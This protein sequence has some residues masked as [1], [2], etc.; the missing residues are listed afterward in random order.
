MSAWRVIAER[1]RPWPAAAAR[2]LWS[3]GASGVRRLRAA[4]PRRRLPLLVAGAAAAVLVGLAPRGPLLAG[5][6]LLVAAVARGRR[7]ARAA[8]PEDP[9]TRAERHRR[10]ATV[11][12]ALV[13][14]FR[15]PEEAPEAGA[16]AYGG[17]WEQAVAEYAFDDEG[18]VAGLCLHYPAHFPDGD[19]EARSRVE[20]VLA[21]KTGG[22]RELA[23]EWD[24]ERTLLRLRVLPPL[25]V[26]LHAQRFVTGP[27]ETVLGFT[28]PGAVD[29]TM[30]V[31]PPG[32]VAESE[33]APQTADAAPV[34]WR[35]GP[36]CTAAHLLVAAS[37]GAGA[38][39]LLRSI[40]L[41]A[42]R[43]GE[44]LVVDGGGSGEFACFLGRR[45][46]L[47]VESCAQGA[48]GALEWVARETERRLSLV[49]R[50]RQAPGAGQVPRVSP[51][52]VVVDRPDQLGH[53]ARL[54]G[55]A[56]PLRLLEVPLRHGRAAQV[57]VVVAE[58][59]AGLPSL[60]GTV[61]ECAEARVVLGTAPA[62][63]VAGVLGAPPGGT[64]PPRAVPGRGYARLGP[65]PVYRLQVPA[66]PDPGDDTARDWEREAV[67][68]LLPEPILAAAPADG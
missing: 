46:V 63:E 10:L 34:V 5:A 62:W 59:L 65:G 41:Q 56:D 52:W 42:L 11:Y 21:A 49:G 6:A 45:G 4:P 31:L 32:A 24:P 20:A 38:T 50:A 68:D 13:P 23:F 35:T 64:P 9:A 19:P 37:P 67:L 60:S 44:I 47:S 22:D 28:D 39:S 30:P 16:Y 57:A 7:L 27:G 18:R 15:A 1:T 17:D 14:Y 40:A 48:A 36:R 33:P 8:E 2:G 26:G 3:L 25:P 54:A 53:L 29:R 12:E 61:L 58:R 43:G 51:L 66:T 55:L